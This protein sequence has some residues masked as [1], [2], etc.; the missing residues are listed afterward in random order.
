MNDINRMNRRTRNRARGIADLFN[1]FSNAAATA[2]GAYGAYNEERSKAATINMKSQL[3]LDTNNFLRT[4]ENAGDTDPSQVQKKI[5]DFMANK[6]NPEEGSFYRPRNNMEASMFKSVLDENLNNIRL[7]ADEIVFNNQ[8]SQARVDLNKALDNNASIYGTDYSGRVENSLFLIE[9]NKAATGMSVEDAANLYKKENDK[10]A[11]DCVSAMY[12]SK[13][14]GM[15]EENESGIKEEIKE[16]LKKVYKGEGNFD[17]AVEE[18]FSEGKRKWNE[19]QRE[20]NNKWEDSNFEDIIKPYEDGS[21]TPAQLIS[22]IDARI[23][24]IEKDSDYLTV[25]DKKARINELL[26]IRDNE[27]AIGAASSGSASGAAQE[28]ILTWSQIASNMKGGAGTFLR[29][30]LNS[31]K[32]NENVSLRQMIDIFNASFNESI[33]ERVI[34]DRR[35][36]LSDT[37][38][39]QNKQNYIDSAIKNIYDNITK[40]EYPSETSGRLKVALSNINK[41][42]DVATKEWMTKSFVAFLL[43]SGRNIS[44]EQIKNWEKEAKLYS[45][46]NVDKIVDK[47]GN[48]VTYDIPSYNDMKKAQLQTQQ[49]PELLNNGP[50]GIES[51]RT[52]YGEALYTSQLASYGKIQLVLMAKEKGIDINMD[53]IT[54]HF[55]MENGDVNGRLCYTIADENFKGKRFRLDASFGHFEIQ[56]LSG[57]Y[58]NNEVLETYK[59]KKDDNKIKEN[60]KKMEEDQTKR[61]EEW[62]EKHKQGNEAYNEAYQKRLEGLDNAVDRLIKADKRPENVSALI[63]KDMN[64]EEKK[65][66]WGIVL[67]SEPGDLNSWKK[68]YKDYMGEDYE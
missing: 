18:G 35:Q 43:N 16:E 56:T 62:K 63:W 51:A 67:T 3:N 41:V 66:A 26:R 23:N 14:P 29:K 2:A 59:I 44:E 34:E 13:A 49:N 54:T 12:V 68:V 46:F 38:I 57:D 1:A 39:A 60:N 42:K 52:N 19:V 45:S 15:S 61:K 5:N 33:T 36:G 17:K 47:D 53:D 32:D 40:I 24:E 58:K 25:D 9:A 10:A 30:M 6:N 27:E 21:K 28:E 22:K 31:S 8:V 37:Q 55:D 7:K 50:Y 64:D 11:I 4:L 48:A 65:N 20:H